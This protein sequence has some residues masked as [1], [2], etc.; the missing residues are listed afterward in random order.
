LG[1][2]LYDDSRAIELEDRTLAHLQVV[3][4]DKLRRHESFALNLDDGEHAVMMW[5]NP[6]TPLQFVYVGNRH[7]KLNRLW[8]EEL[9]SEA[10]LTGV[11]VLLREPPEQ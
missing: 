9:A 3:I 5:M 7:P 2:F 11:L 8:L 4:I 10:S 1:F 6:C